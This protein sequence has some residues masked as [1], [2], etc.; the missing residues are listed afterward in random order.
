MSPFS[1][2]DFLHT[3]ALFGV[4]LP[5]LSRAVT[6]AKTPGTLVTIFL[7]GG[8]DG[9]GMVQPV[10]DPR[11]RELR[12]GLVADGPPLDRFFSLHPA[13]APLLPLY[14][15]KRLAVVHAVGQARPS[16]SH[17][18]AQDFLE[19]GLAGQRGHDGYLNRALQ[20]LGGGEGQPFRVVALQ[21]SLPLSLA[22]EAPALALPSLQDFKVPGGELGAATFDSLYADAV[23]EAL[24][25]TGRDAF[26][27]VEQTGSLAAIAPSNG[28]SYPKS[29]LGKRLQDIAR[30]IHGEVGLRIAATEATG[31]DTHLAQGAATGTL[32]ARLKDLAEALA[33]F[34]ADLGPRLDEVTVVTMTE[35]GRT[36]REN[37]TRGT[38]HGTA[39]ALFTLGGGVRGGQVYAAWPGLEDAK[40]FEKRDLAVTTDVRAVLSEALQHA[41]AVSNVFPGYAPARLGLF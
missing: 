19:S 29:P 40:L 20:Q 3:L 1:R 14:Q 23:D 25:S 24:R 28:A 21:S 4:S 7:R 18:D 9:L 37:G 16:R 26:A 17:F 41:L 38:D 10:G 12:P 30:L 36:A 39:S 6:T 8:V 11:L 34:A 15:R 5:S 32:A 35:F 22:G 31:F 27:G 33:A 2:R 13:L